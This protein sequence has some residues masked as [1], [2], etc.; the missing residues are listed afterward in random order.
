MWFPG[1][2]VISPKMLFRY[3]IISKVLLG[4]VNVKYSS[5]RYRLFMLTLNYSEVLFLLPCFVLYDVLISTIG[6][7]VYTF[8]STNI[9]FKVHGIRR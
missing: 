4:P 9:E 3:S 7:L 2:V 1:M 6:S 5:N 8:D